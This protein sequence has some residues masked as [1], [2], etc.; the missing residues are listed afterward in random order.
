MSRNCWK[1]LEM[2][3]IKIE[4]DRQKWLRIGG[5]DWNWLEI[6]GN[7]NGNRNG[8]DDDDPDYDD[9]DDDDN[10]DDSIGGPFDSLTVS[11]K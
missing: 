2:A 8:S 3:V 6:A 1:W 10:D 4:E 7:A 5:N 9:N 11:C